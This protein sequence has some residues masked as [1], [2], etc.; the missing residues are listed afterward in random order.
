VPKKKYV[1]VVDE[2]VNGEA[3]KK[4]ATLLY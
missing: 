1:T 2:D 3:I 4:K